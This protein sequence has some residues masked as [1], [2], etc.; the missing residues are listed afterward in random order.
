MSDFNDTHDD[1]LGQLRREFE[2]G[3]ADC[4]KL[5]IAQEEQNK[6][7]KERLELQKQL[8]IS[9]STNATRIASFAFQIETL[10][11]KIERMAHNQAIL[12]QIVSIIATANISKESLHD[13]KDLLSSLKI[14]NIGNISADK[15]DI[16]SEIGD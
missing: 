14:V 13:V 7:L 12:I 5:R 15:G 8:Q 3:Y 11:E 10:I 2:Q 9:M 1:I 4:Y 16:H 6:M